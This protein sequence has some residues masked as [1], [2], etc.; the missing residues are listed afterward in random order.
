LSDSFISLKSLFDLS[1]KTAVVTGGAGW[2]GTAISEA[3]AELGASVYVASRSQSKRDL[4]IEEV[5]KV[6]PEAKIHGITLDITDR[7]SVE[8]CFSDVSAQKGSIDILIN[9][10]YSGGSGSIE[11]TTD[12][13]WATTIDAGLTG[14][15]RCIQAALPYLKASAGGTVVNI[16]SMYGLVAPYPDLYEGNHFLNPPAYG[17]AKAAIIQLTRYSAVHLAQYGLRV[18]CISPGPFPAPK[19]QE[20]ATFVQRLAA[21]TPLGRV[22]RPSELKGAVAYLS[23]PASSYVTG[24]N[25]V[26]DGGWTCW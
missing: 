8:R 17:A 15:Q 20:N 11:Q 22:G 23:S 13:D 21:K 16:A 2:L 3:L 26:V 5:I 9:N 7:S 18:N 6:L 4:A 10:A 1:G 25:I 12:Q 24:Q 14:Y 19:V